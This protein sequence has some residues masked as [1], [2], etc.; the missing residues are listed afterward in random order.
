MN[1]KKRKLLLGVFGAIVAFAVVI[2]A[3]PWVGAAL[4]G[5]SIVERALQEQLLCGVEVGTVS[6][7]WGGFA[8]DRLVLTQPAGSADVGEPLLE[9][10]GVELRLGSL[11]E[12]VRGRA[13]VGVKIDRVRAVVVRGADGVTNLQR[14]K[15]P[16]S[17]AELATS[18]RKPDSG[19]TKHELAPFGLRFELR[20]GTVVLR[21]LETR[22]EATLD[23]L[24]ASARRDAGSRTLSYAL[25]CDVASA[26]RSGA[27]DVKGSFDFEKRGHA[28]DIAAER[29]N[30][31]AFSPL[32]AGTRWASSIEGMADGKVRIQADDE[33]KISGDGSLTIT[34]FGVSGGGLAAPV[35][36]PRISVSPKF[37]VDMGRGTV[38]LEGFEL[39]TSALRIAGKGGF[40]QGSGGNLDLEWTGDLSKAQETLSAFFPEKA[41][42]SGIV[43]GKAKWT[44]PAV[45]DSEFLVAVDAM[46]VSAAPRGSKPLT[47]DGSLHLTGSVSSDFRAAAV[48]E[49]DVAFGPVASARFSGTWKKSPGA[50][51]PGEFDARFEGDLSLDALVQRMAG[52]FPEKLGLSGAVKS[53]GTVHTSE[54][55]EIRWSFSGEALA[56]RI[57]VK[58]GSVLDAGDP[59][60]LAPLAAN[61][62]A[63][64]RVTCRAEGTRDPRFERFEL[65]NL[66]VHASSGAIEGTARAEGSWRSLTS[67]LQASV[68]V[69]GNLEKLAPYAAAWLPPRLRLGGR[70]AFDLD[71]TAEN[72][73]VRGPVQLSA[74]DVRIAGAAGPPGSHSALD[75]WFDRLGADPAVL[76]G[77]SLRGD[78]DMDPHRSA[79]VVPNLTIESDPRAVG[80]SGSLA[81]TLSEPQSGGS[82]V[83]WEGTVRIDVP[84]CASL[85]RA[86]AR[87]GVKGEGAC[88]V[89]SGFRYERDAKGGYALSVRSNANLTELSR[90]AE[91]FTEGEFAYGGR[92]SLTASVSMDEPTLLRTFDVRAS[93]TNLEAGDAREKSVALEGAGQYYFPDGGFSADVKRIALRTESGGA[94]F[95][96]SG[97][98]GVRA[99]APFFRGTGSGSFDV[100]WIS[101][102]LPGRGLAHDGGVRF[103][104]DAAPSGS[105]TSIRLDAS[106]AGVRR[107]G[108]SADGL[109]PMDAALRAAMNLTGDN[110]TFEAL[111]SECPTLGW[112]FKAD[113]LSIGRLWSERNLAGALACEIDA[114]ALSEALQAGRAHRI[115]VQGSG[116]AKATLGGRLASEPIRNV[117]LEGEFTFPLV[118]IGSY[119]ASDVK[120]NFGARDGT[121]VANGEA[122]RI[123][124]AATGAGDAGR[125][126]FDLTAMPGGDRAFRARVKVDGVPASTDLA[127]PLARVLPVFG[128]DFKFARVEGSVGLD[129]NVEGDL[130]DWR[131]TLRG[132]ARTSVSRV[133]FADAGDF[134]SLTEFLRLKSLEGKVRSID[135]SSRIG[136]GRISIVNVL[137]D[138]DPARLPIR[139]SVTFDGQ[140]DAKVDLASAKLG[141]SLE[142]YKPLAALFEPRFGG[143]VDSVKFGISAPPPQRVVEEAARIAAGSILSGERVDAGKLGRVRSLADLAALDDDAEEPASAPA[144]AVVRTDATGAMPAE[145][146]ARF[147]AYAKGAN[148]FD[149]AA[150]GRNKT[151]TSQLRAWLESTPVAP[152]GGDARLADALNRYEVALALAV[153]AAV[154]DPLFAVLNR[155][156]GVHG[157][158]GFFTRPILVSGNQT[159]LTEMSLAIRQVGG[160]EA[161]FRIPGAAV[162]LPWIDR[163]G[164]SAADVKRSIEDRAAAVA[165]RS[166]WNADRGAL[167]VP[168]IVF[169]AFRDDE[170]AIRAFLERRLPADHPA[171]GQ[172]AVCR[173]AKQSEDLALDTP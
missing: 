5:K 4:F 112:S 21:D 124:L 135:V 165:A 107:H 42:V 137:V 36:E 156:K 27:L 91:A 131:S 139:G 68:H 153:A 160:D 149:Y 69:Q 73:R 23:S 130:D 142:R 129:A 2:A 87:P 147:R 170:A 9:V 161:V 113:R 100:G 96:C 11:L 57:G 29:V 51:G 45:G 22:L 47:T 88:E 102:Y 154:E 134:R 48:R 77:L 19:A 85:F 162:D 115:R 79:L 143:S 152:L 24:T 18:R 3:A 60:W 125:A 118:E 172:L 120:G 84:A 155:K 64:D 13:D 158:E 89:E 82:A 30:L 37:T 98:G 126:S 95:E 67:T 148:R 74:S 65:R 25:H 110:L 26:G 81:W 90:L 28:V 78:V 53:T 66:E 171:R 157:V 35:R 52:L 58:S 104:F 166:R 71:L 141:R 50:P 54:T 146:S 92:G 133:H 97:S 72:G 34:D 63:E 151:L 173:L 138:G 83:E 6:G 46:G 32:V 159:T 132:D 119:H 76:R 31:A 116:I 43:S 93:V 122:A 136:E 16:P 17:P 15:R 40:E 1:P 7:G 33:A 169:R 80:A 140:V 150:L 49:G 39:R 145:L 86:L 114:G 56:L 55:Q 12:A 8:L 127:A 99:G 94:S 38:S 121:L 164:V 103:T 105:S 163:S 168:A 167:A 20:H 41:I 123:A 108:E 109:P 144:V 14:V 111:E 106:A 117:F 61:P 70:A 101:R 10:M 59:G 44:A 62:I 75:N 128:E